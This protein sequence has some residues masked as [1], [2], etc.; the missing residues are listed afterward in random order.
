MV[1][2]IYGSLATIWSEFYLL[3]ELM[4]PRQ[5][6]YLPFPYYTFS[7]SFVFIQTA[8]LDPNETD[9]RTVSENIY[10]C[11][12]LCHHLGGET[13]VSGNVPSLRNTWFHLPSLWWAGHLF[14]HVRMHCIIHLLGDEFNPL[15]SCCF[16][17]CGVPSC[18]CHCSGKFLRFTCEKSVPS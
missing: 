6:H 14:L 7:L 10:D 8:S 4:G 13:C 15:F 18:Y 9:R 17:Y 11:S 12:C 1:A 3:F 5:P 16:V 2:W